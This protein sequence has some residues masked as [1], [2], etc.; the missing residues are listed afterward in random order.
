MSIPNRRT[1]LGLT[2]A[3]LGSLLFA[4]HAAAA[5]PVVDV[6]R[7]PGCGCCG[8]WIGHMRAEGFTVRDRLAEDLAP[9]KSR[10]GVPADLQSCH[11]ATVDGYVIEGHVPAR[12]VRR[13]LEERPSAIGLAVSGMPMGSPGMETGGAADSYEVLLFGAERQS[14]FARY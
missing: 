4:R 13:L 6:A 3:G 7:S 5:Q 14:V 11:T 1:M 8:G 9:L 12:E 10:L 2:A